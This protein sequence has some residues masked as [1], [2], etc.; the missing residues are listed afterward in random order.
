MWESMKVFIIA[1][2]DNNKERVLAHTLLMI[3]L[4]V[5]YV[6]SFQEACLGPLL[7]LRK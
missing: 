5:L 1:N 3:T 2:T 4:L 6:H 7:L